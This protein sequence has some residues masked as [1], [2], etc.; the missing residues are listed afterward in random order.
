MESFD[1]GDCD[2][3]RLVL[4]YNAVCREVLDAHDPATTRTFSVRVKPNWYTDEVTAARRARR[5]AERHWRKTE[6]DVDHRLYIESQRNV[7]KIIASAKKDYYCS[8]FSSC[9]TRDV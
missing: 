5:R 7:C 2:L 4:E 3:N 6:T 1:P 9:N 8:R